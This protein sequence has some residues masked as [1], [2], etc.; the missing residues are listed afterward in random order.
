MFSFQKL[1]VY[2]KSLDLS[3]SLTKVA[4][5]FPFSFSRIR[6]QLIGAV[7]SITLNIAEGCGRSGN[8]EKMQFFKIARGSA[9]ELV[10]I[11]EICE[12][13]NLI[14]KDDYLAEIESICKMLNGLINKYK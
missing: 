9:F 2:Q 10:S 3:V 7:T 13:I 12:K 6:D 4:S 14:T 11:V 5:G 8:K 1:V